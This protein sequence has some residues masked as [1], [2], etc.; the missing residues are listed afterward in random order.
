MTSVFVGALRQGVGARVDR[1]NAVVH[2]A[3]PGPVM[4]RI[5]AVAATL[6]GFAVTWPAR[7]LA[8]T[9]IVVPVL[10]GIGVGLAPRSLMPTTAIVAMVLGYLYNI[11]SGA[12]LTAWRAI[13]AAA[14]IYVVHTC[15]AF[16]A[17]LPF[18]AVATRGLFGPF[19]LRIA[20]VIGVTAV[21]GLGIL[22]VPGA[23][24]THRL[25]SAAVGG[26]VAMVGVAAYVAYLGSRR[27]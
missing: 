6:A 16:A 8:T 13:V 7:D 25:V 14:L 26:M 27:R 11:S 2:Q 17:V 1:A 9:A 22:S 4:V 19:V 3:K 18:N 20:A 5:A 10:L 15:A 24:G 21:L 23:L 12:P